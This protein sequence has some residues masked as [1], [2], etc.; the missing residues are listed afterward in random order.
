MPTTGP[1]P[2]CAGRVR[3]RGADPRRWHVLP[4]DRRQRSQGYWEN[5]T[6][7]AGMAGGCAL[8]VLDLALLAFMVSILARA[9]FWLFGRP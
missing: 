2:I 3:K 5:K 4:R 6:A 7:R 1:G 9:A 8:V